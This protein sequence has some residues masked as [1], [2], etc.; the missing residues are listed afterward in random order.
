LGITVIE[1]DRIVINPAI[2]AGVPCIAGTRIP[3]T[4]IL[5]F[6]WEGSSPAEILGYYPQLVLDDVLACVKYATS[7]GDELKLNEITPPFRDE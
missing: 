4:T 5:G 1:V 6:L 7:S 2:M 3:V